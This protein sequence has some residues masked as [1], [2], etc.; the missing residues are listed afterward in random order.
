MSMLPGDAAVEETTPVLK[1]RSVLLCVGGGIAAYKAC[2]VARLLLRAGATV[3]VAMTAAAQQ[4]VTPLT[5]QALTQRPVATNLLDASEEQQIG[6]IGLADRAELAIVAPATAD[7][8]A[9]LRAGMA[10]DIVTTALLATRAPVLIAPSMNV[11]MW[12]HAATRENISALQ[13]RGY[14]QVGPGSGEMACGHVGD[15]RLAEPWDIV[16]AAARVL[17]PRD[18]IGKRVLITAGPTREHIDPVRFVSNPSTGKMGYA[19][20]AAALARGAQVV[21]VSGPVSIDAPPGAQL[22]SVTSAAEMAAAVMQHAN[23]ADVIVMSAAV[24]DY[25]P[26]EVHPQK[27]KKSEGAETLTFTRTQDIL[28]SLGKR[29][30][31]ASSRPL[32]V[33]FAAETENVVEHAREKLS[34]KG[35]DL[36]V[37][38]FV[39]AGG[40]FGAS[41]NEVVLVAKAF[42]R[43]LPRASKETIARQ[44][45]DEIVSR[46]GVRQPS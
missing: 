16:R 23:A 31:G 45:V 43:P 15:G 33:G 26:I 17:G 25:R 2:E 4:F 22:L 30:A 39:G 1:G 20:A 9:R 24:S 7:L 6:H 3:D 42:E 46:L 32:L 12:N 29:F 28:A 34:R 11:H 44:I 40:A 19:V 8:C 21:L 41:D 35:A 27:V 5:M 10:N 38:N 13:A 36:I 37:A 18:L 14:Q